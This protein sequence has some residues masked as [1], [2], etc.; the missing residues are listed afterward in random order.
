[1]RVATGFDWELLPNGNVLIDFF[2]DE[3]TVFNQQIVTP[4]VVQNLPIVAAL[5]NVALKKG[6]EAVK[7]IM[8]RLNNR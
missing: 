3:G 4:E 6:P 1:M 5:V 8:D 2:G 7:D